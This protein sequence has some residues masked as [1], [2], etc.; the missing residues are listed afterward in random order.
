MPHSIFIETTIPSYYVARPSRD[1]LQLG[2]VE[3][4][5]EEPLGGAHR[6]P[7][8]VA[9]RLR[10]SILRFWK[11]IDTTPVETLLERRY[12]RFRNIGAFSS[13]QRTA[14]TPPA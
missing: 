9:Q 3:E 1:L 4:V 10:A 7:E 2:I 11:T 5:I 6:D 8:L 13:Q 14:F 12:E